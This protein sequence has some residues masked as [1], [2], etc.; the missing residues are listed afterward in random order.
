MPIDNNKRKDNQPTPLISFIITCYNLPETM[1]RQCVE[2]ILE[3]SLSRQER[4]IIIVD[5]GS[6]YPVSSAIGPLA[7]ETIVL[8]QENAGP[9]MA[10]NA[11]LN[12]AKGEYIQFVDGDDCL[13]SAEYEHCLG[14][15]RQS[16]P[17]M[18]M[19]E[20]NTSNKFGMRASDRGPMTGVEYMLQHNLKGSVWSYAFRRDILG[21]L[22]FAQAINNHE[23]EEFTPLLT[24]RAKAVYSTTAKAYYYRFR[25][26]SLTNTSDQYL[27]RR[28]MNDFRDVIMKLQKALDSLNGAEHEALKRRIDQLAMD[29]LVTDIR[30]Y[31]NI[32]RLNTAA[33]QL[34][35]LGLYPLA[36]AGYT[37]KYNIFRRLMKRS[38]GRKILI[39][40]I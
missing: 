36:D 23:D 37:W 9:G 26:D 2:S 11:G 32:P 22:R 4:E 14:I 24:L 12:V 15:I 10:R 40:A 3:L 6:E 17:D 39:M 33:E 13:L 19:F 28:Q 27:Q 1:I 5:D 31:H 34:K 21:S 20:Y 8:R 29:Y 25:K 35:E 30:L 16:H 18:V 38:I 7:K